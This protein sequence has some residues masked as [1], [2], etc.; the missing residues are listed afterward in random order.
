[1]R[2]VEDILDYEGP[3]TMNHHRV[4]AKDIVI[5]TPYRTRYIAYLTALNLLQEKRP[6]LSLA[7]LR[8]RK[9]DQFQSC[10]QS[11]VSEGV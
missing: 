7:E 8:V 2:L 9:F 4:A 5:L 1:M 6:E 3:G 10:E 11:R